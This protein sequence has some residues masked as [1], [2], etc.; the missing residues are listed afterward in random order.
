MT[1]AGRTTTSAPAARAG[2]RAE[3][4]V[5]PA[6]ADWPDR[7]ARGEVPGRWPYGLDE[8]AADGRPVSLTGLAEVGRLQAAARVLRRPRGTVGLAWNENT[9]RRMV[10]SGRYERMHCGIIWADAGWEELPARTR[11]GLRRTLAR[12]ASVWTLSGA[13]LDRLD[14][15]VPAATPRHVVTFGIDERF[16][17]LAPYPE[18]PLL[19]SVGG[20]RHRDQATV[21]EAF[22]RVQQA[23][24]GTDALVQSA[25]PLGDTGSVRVVERVSHA[26]L[27][28]LYR[29]ASVVAVAT[30]PNHHVS[31]M[32]VSLEAQATGRPVV[33]TGTPG[34]DDYVTDGETGFLTAVGSA[35]E[36]AD[37]IVALLDDPDRACAMG[38]SG[39]SAVE[40]RFTSRHLAQRLGRAVGLR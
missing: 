10:R 13:Q 16:F 14:G 11:R 34:A 25:R 27:R 36:I 31:G 28:D 9:A 39:R 8:L 26:E 7:H 32:T 37:R 29:R 33:L 35:D 1:S 20:D 18:R 19:L 4:V 15:L 6:A 17:A 22:R 5:D 21:L 23:R 12:M 30:R 24:P 2:V 38:R 3:L 40:E